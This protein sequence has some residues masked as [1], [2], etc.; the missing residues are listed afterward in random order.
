MAPGCPGGPHVEYESVLLQQRETTALW[1]MLVI[2]AE[3]QQVEGVSLILCSALVRLA[4]RLGG[5]STWYSRRNWERW[6]CWALRREGEGRR[7]L[8]AVCGKIQNQTSLKGA[9]QWD[10][11]QWTQAGLATTK[12]FLVL[13][14]FNLENGQTLKEG[15]SEC[16]EHPS[17]EVLELDR[18]R[19]CATTSNSACAG[20]RI[21]IPPNLNCPCYSV[22][23]QKP[24]IIAL[25]MNCWSYA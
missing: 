22:I 1:S 24:G 15:S 4:R 12:V 6:V 9:W 2:V 3:G 21:K 23:T 19:A 11:R 25:E 16:V 13:F 18:T 14:V 20:W 17:M 8:A 5:W 10:E 7:D